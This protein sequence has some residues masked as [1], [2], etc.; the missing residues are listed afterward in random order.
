MCNILCFRWDPTHTPRP[1]L[2]SRLYK[3]TPCAHGKCLPTMLAAYWG[4]T[5]LQESHRTVWP[6]HSAQSIKLSTRVV[7]RWTAF[8]YP[9]R[10]K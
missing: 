10:K 8:I 1:S 6:K 9:N 7:M 5:R 3:P 2:R 4:T